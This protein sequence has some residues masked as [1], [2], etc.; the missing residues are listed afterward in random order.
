LHFSCRNKQQIPK[1]KDTYRSRIFHLF[2]RRIE[3]FLLSHC[4][5]SKTILL[6]VFKICRWIAASNTHTSSETMK[7]K[8]QKP[9]D[10]HV[11][12]DR[13]SNLPDSLL[14]HI[15][16]FVDSDCAVQT[17]ILSTRWKNLWKHL[18]TLTLD[19]S[20]FI[21]QKNFTKFVSV[22]SPTVNSTAFP[23]FWAQW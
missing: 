10:D 14:H 18:P 12:E 6:L 7:P 19:S 16:S 9:N 20:G 15:L 1:N 17:C 21:H 11:E 8:R 2:G 23:R 22:S 5:Y 3:V 4:S 13:L